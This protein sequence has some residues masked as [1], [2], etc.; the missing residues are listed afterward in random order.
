MY[1]RR[2]STPPQKRKEGWHGCLAS[3]DQISLA[4]YWS[5]H[6]GNLKCEGS[7]VFHAG[8]WFLAISLRITTPQ[9][10]NNEAFG[11]PRKCRHY[12]GMPDSPHSGDAPIPY[13][14]RRSLERMRDKRKKILEDPREYVY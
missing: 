9:G 13:A 6:F 10:T 7:V 2:Q 5:L 11:T 12:A 1:R 14:V 8:S 3:A 4:E